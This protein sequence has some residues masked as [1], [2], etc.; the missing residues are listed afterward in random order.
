MANIDLE[1]VC[2]TLMGPAARSWRFLIDYSS[3][4]EEATIIRVRA[5][6]YSL[7]K[8]DEEVLTKCKG[9]EQALAEWLQGAT[10]KACGLIV[11]ALDESLDRPPR[12]KTKA[13]F[14]A[15]PK[16]GAHYQT[17]RSP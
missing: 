8:L 11:D 17:G 1:R 14:I 2:N 9:D 7:I 12:L 15:C 3:P 10:L 4:R 5:G 16:C 13:G 6:E